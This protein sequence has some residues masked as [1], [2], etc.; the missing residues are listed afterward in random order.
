MGGAEDIGDVLNCG[1]PTLAW[2]NATTK[3]MIGTCASGATEPE[4][5]DVRVLSIDRIGRIVL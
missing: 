2:I 3:V 4:L 5:C 1:S